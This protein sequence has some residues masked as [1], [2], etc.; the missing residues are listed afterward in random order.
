MLFLN[1]IIAIIIQKYHKIKKRRNYNKELTEPEREWVHI[2]KIFMKYHPIPKL[3]IPNQETFRKKISKIV[4]SK[5]F[6]LIIS[7]LIIL[8]CCN[9]VIQHKG[10]SK[11]Y[12]NTLTI[13][14]LCFSLLFTIEL[15]M[16]L[17]VY[18]KLYFMNNWNIFDFVIIILGDLLA[19]LN[20]LSFTNFTTYL[21]N[22]KIN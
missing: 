14:N 2:Q 4:T 20:I 16:K 13:I 8:S 6:D 12:D 21:Q 3:R 15:I 10:S 11:F 1:L 18:R 17:I 19:I 7:I 22:I 9:L 5:K